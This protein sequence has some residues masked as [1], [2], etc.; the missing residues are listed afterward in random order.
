MHKTHQKPKHLGTH[1]TRNRARKLAAQEIKPG[2]W[3][4]TGGELGHG[5]TVTG[6]PPVYC[7]DCG[8][9]EFARSGMCSHILAVW[10]AIHGMFEEAT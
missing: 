5:V 2:T 1:R 8:R 3:L 6:S 7:C 10:L 9:Q 4:V